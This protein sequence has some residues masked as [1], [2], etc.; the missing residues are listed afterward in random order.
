LHLKWRSDRIRTCD[1]YVPKLDSRFPGHPEMS[2]RLRVISGQIAVA[3][4]WLWKVDR[5]PRTRWDLV[6]GAVALAGMGIVVWGGW[7]TS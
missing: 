5:V 3:L 1:I 2:R 6:G 4:V 7:R